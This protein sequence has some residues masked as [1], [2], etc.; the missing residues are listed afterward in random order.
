MLLVRLA[1][2]GMANYE[3][4]RLERASIDVPTMFIQATRDNVLT[5][6]M[7]VGMEKHLPNLRRYEVRASHWAL[8]EKPAE[9]NG[10]IKEWL[11]VVLPNTRSSL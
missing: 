7:S 10:S 11:D 4:A 9:V 3:T 6:A 8:W 2:C 5:P 1:D